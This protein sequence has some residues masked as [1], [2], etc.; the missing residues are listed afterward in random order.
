LPRFVEKRDEL[1]TKLSSVFQMCDEICDGFLLNKEKSYTEIYP[2]ASTDP[3]KAAEDK[4]K[5]MKSKLEAAIQEAKS[6]TQTKLQSKNNDRKRQRRNR[7][8]KRVDDNHTKKLARSKTFF[9][10]EDNADELPV[11]ETTKKSEKRQET[12]IKSASL[13]WESVSLELETGGDGF[14]ECLGFLLNPV[15]PDDD[16]ASFVEVLSKKLRDSCNLDDSTIV[17]LL[18]TLDYSEEELIVEMSMGLNRSIIIHEWKSESEM[19]L[20]FESQVDDGDGEFHVLHCNKDNNFTANE[21][22]ELNH[23]RPLRASTEEAQDQNT[24]EA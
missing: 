10:S 5:E 16:H 20:A 9:I 21:E 17:E 2:M 14:L 4:V 3:K 22:V 1:V 23:Y 11:F 12:R 18:G 19:I 13:G 8:K 7:K 24:E 6:T 15:D